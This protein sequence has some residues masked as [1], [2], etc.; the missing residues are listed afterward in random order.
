MRTGIRPACARSGGSYRG[1]QTHGGARVEQVR[2]F[3]STRLAQ[4]PPRCPF[5][6]PPHV[7]L[8][9]RQL[10]SLGVPGLI[11]R[12]RVHRSRHSGSR[13]RCSVPRSRSSSRLPTS[14]WPRRSRA[15]S[16][17]R[18]SASP[19]ARRCSNH[20]APPPSAGEGGVG[21]PTVGGNALTQ[22]LLQARYPCE[23]LRCAR[24]PARPRPTIAGFGRPRAWHVLRSARRIT[25]A[26]RVS[27]PC[28]RPGC[29]HRSSRR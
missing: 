9:K 24:H 25:G 5:L 8:S 28:D 2:S 29:P 1:R 23:R 12:R 4:G 7:R 11:L 16:R 22:D 27:R 18:P 17:R 13:C 19:A 3:V 10:R 6:R 14:T 20:R 15:T 21:R 26:P